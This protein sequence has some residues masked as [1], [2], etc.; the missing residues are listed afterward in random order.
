MQAPAS[1]V[2]Q[3][4][5]RHEWAVYSSKHGMES[6][7]TISAGRSK[8]QLSSTS[9]D[10]AGG[11]GDVGQVGPFAFWAMNCRCWQNNDC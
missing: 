3:P 6:A 4:T 11:T 7:D 8:D 1:S 10:Q 9:Q 5:Q 2:C